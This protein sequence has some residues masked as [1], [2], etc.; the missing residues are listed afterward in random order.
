MNCDP[1][2]ELMRLGYTPREAAFLYLA[3][4]FS[5]FFV[6]RQYTEFVCRERGA[7]LQQFVRKAQNRN[8]IEILHCGPGGHVYHLKS[9]L[10]YRILGF[11]D[12]QNR[13]LKGDDEIKTR[14]MVLDYILEH[15]GR[16]FASSEREKVTFFRDALR[17]CEVDLP[18]TTYANTRVRGEMAI[19]YFADRFPI[20]LAEGKKNSSRIVEFTYFDNGARS[21]KPFH[22][23]LYTYKPILVALGTFHLVYVADT[24]RNFV[25]AAEL[26]KKTFAQADDGCNRQLL[27]FG[28]DHLVHFFAARERWDSNSPEFSP[29]DLKFLKEGEK[30]YL[31]PQHNR[32]HSAW[33]GCRAAFEQE[34]NSLGLRKDIKASFQTHLLPAIYP[35][36]GSRYE[37]KGA[38]RAFQVA[39]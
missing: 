12:S 23:H 39:F 2:P 5:G 32:L 35:I 16:Q 31:R 3:G 28:A 11:E 38:Q 9:M 29:E 27:P 6:G 36:F 34:M 15:S 19:R 1:T 21:T 18:A 13:R 14:L 17:L 24:E 37:A 33:K 22:R 7:I 26:F 30:V 8:H 4:R 25:A 10:I 20:A